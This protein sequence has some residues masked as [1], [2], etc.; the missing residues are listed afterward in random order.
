MQSLPDGGGLGERRPASAD[1]AAEGWLD[2]PARSALATMLGWRRS[3]AQALCAR[4]DKL[5]GSNARAR[6]RSCTA[7]R[8]F[9]FAGLR[10]RLMT[11]SSDAEGPDQEIP[12]LVHD[13]ML[14]SIVEAHFAVWYVWHVPTGR[15]IVPGMRELLDIDDDEVPTIVE[16]WMGRVHPHDLPR[17]VGENDEALRSNSAF[18]SE[19]RLRRGN[20]E[21]ISISDWGIVL[22]GDDG[23]A[24]W[25][26]GGLR[27]ITIE[28][29]LERA[30]E[31]SAQLREVL[32]NKALMPAFLVD[33]HGV[34][35]DASR[36]ALTL[37]QIERAALLGKPAASIFPPELVAW[38]TRLDPGDD[39][40]DTFGTREV[41]LQ[42][43]GDRKWL[44][45]TVVPFVVGEQEMAFV[46]GID[47]TERRRAADALARSEASLREKTRD[48]ERHNVA[49][50]VL[51]EQR[52][53]DLEERRRILAENVEQLVLPTLDRAAAAFADRPEVA[54]LDVVKNT[55]S[56][57]TSPLLE[58]GV[59]QSDH[60]RGLSRREYEI[61]QLVRA[62][63]TT[64]EIARA[65][66][67]SPSTVSFHRGNI[68]E[69]L[70]LRG[71]GVRLAARVAVGPAL[72]MRSD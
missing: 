20:G 49:L 58:G 61:L 14:R 21:Y 59:S 52:R 26:A 56:E 19:Y 53:T 55:L 70:D 43:N 2:E 27:D 50:Q 15:M 37:L 65:L 54:L 16:D 23:T 51:I 62:G 40:E 38:A 63:K 46:L 39:A 24:E 44:L 48:L 69:K 64:K 28:K 9:D 4:D 47:M 7:A 3:P 5:V 8:P 17:M 42:V 60:S 35:V 18:R 13:S 10:L 31:E 22:P 57:I 32:F 36:S 12:P 30:R 71:S 41:E 33:G 67:L 72:P 66:H 34:F 1:S 68:R 29:T 11:E 6:G 25:M 45:A